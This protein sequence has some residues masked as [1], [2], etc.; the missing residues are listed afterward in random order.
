M[1]T[2]L[3]SGAI[4]LLAGA[5]LTGAFNYGY[6][7]VLM[8]LLDPAGFAQVA[9]VSSL[10]LVAGTAASA[11]IPWVLAREIANATSVGQR[12]RAVGFALTASLVAGLTAVVVLA[13]AEAGYADPGVMA[14]SAV[15]VAGIF[16]GA[17]GAGYLQGMQRFRLLAGF[18]L[19]EVSVKLVAGI[20]AVVVTGSPV[21]GV[22]G[23]AAGS[24]ACAVWG[25]WL[26]RRD[27]GRPGRSHTGDRRLWKHAAG[28]GGIQTLTSGLLA[29]DVIVLSV[30]AGT[31]PAVAGYQGIL[32]LARTP[33]YVSV[34]LSTIAF[35]RLAAD[36]VSDAQKRRTV[37]EMLAAYITLACLIAAGL[38]AAPQSLLALVLPAHYLAY[39]HLLMPLALAGVFAGLL[40]LLTTFHQA[41]GRYKP[42][43]A[44]L[45]ASFTAGVPALAVAAPADPRL[46]AVAWTSVVILVA[47]SLLA[48]LPLLT[49][50]RTAWRGDAQTGTEV[51]RAA[52]RYAT[53][54][55]R[56]GRDARVLLIGNYGNSN[57]GDESILAGL[58]TLTD[59]PQAITV[60]SRNAA[61]ITALHGVHA[62][63]TVSKASLRGFLTA[64]AIC[65]GGG[66]M[67][68]YGLPPL[69]RLLPFVAI[70][71]RMLGKEVSFLSLGAYATTP[72][73][74]KAPLQLAAYLAT[75]V[76]VRDPESQRVLS[77]GLSRRKDVAVV[78]DPSTL[79][80]PQ[81]ADLDGLG[82]DPRLGAP[83]L[84]NVKAM[85]DRAALDRT[86]A[87][88]AGGLAVWARNHTNPVLVVALSN[89]GD[90]A[91]GTDYSDLRL[92]QRVIDM[93]GL[94]D[95]AVFAGPDLP[96]AVAKG[97]HAASAAVVAVRLHS[98][99]FATTTGTPVL[100]VAFE[101]KARLWLT[102][103]GEEMI[104]T[105]RLAA[106]D[107]AT[108]LARQT[109]TT[110][111]SPA[112]A[113]A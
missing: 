37:T 56:G 103:H 30:L 94:G 73:S 57:T 97:L 47:V 26:M 62:V 43:I 100:G 25:L 10:L 60:V 61:A 58:L 29:Q 44:T 9:A 14:M 49:I 112:T 28:I 33:L 107:V 86:L 80:V 13:A 81:S 90:Y 93:A 69:V 17:T 111:V 41:S 72:A 99:I 87:E 71:A 15:A 66:G 11:T 76:T 79:V 92:G 95:R 5:V 65:I 75:A 109:V 82:L 36:Q 96:P 27:I 104:E 84:L 21:A 31:T 105:D 88:I 4:P 55:R 78:P 113:G 8:R 52:V 6:T 20:T 101:P 110:R 70:T 22:A 59:H 74:T 85:P 23:F 77:T 3:K 50:R 16:V 83:I 35:S 18:R 63:P 51:L 46:T 48:V 34:A 1:K 53:R 12:R 42:M 19:T 32:V 98:Q 67:F 54:P 40:N 45:F 38:L 108:W 106:A 39:Q 2:M 7:L 24:L 64:D 68:G 102:E 89:A 91:L